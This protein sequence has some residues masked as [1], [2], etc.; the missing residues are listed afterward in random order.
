LAVLFAALAPSLAHAWAHQSPA[1]SHGDWVEV[2]TAQ[3]AKWVKADPETGKDTLP[4]SAYK[5]HDCT[6]SCIQGALAD[7][8]PTPVPELP[9]AMRLADVPQALLTRP[10]TLLPW[11]RAQPRAPPMF[12]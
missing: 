3:G 2:C 6:Y 7:V 5:S 1:A 11:V 4:A 12:F 8:L 10:H 9:A